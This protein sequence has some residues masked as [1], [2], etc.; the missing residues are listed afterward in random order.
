ME[1][2]TEVD[3]R[4]QNYRFIRANIPIAV[5]YYAFYYGCGSWP[6]VDL[7]MICSDGK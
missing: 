4:T 7:K 5:E 1:L 3:L 6:V 2:K